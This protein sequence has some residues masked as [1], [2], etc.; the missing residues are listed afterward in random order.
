MQGY[1]AKLARQ[2]IPERKLYVGEIDLCRN[3]PEVPPALLNDLANSINSDE[4]DVPFR[5]SSSPRP[6]RKGIDLEASC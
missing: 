3:L 5:M 1:E 2:P 4:I 6:R